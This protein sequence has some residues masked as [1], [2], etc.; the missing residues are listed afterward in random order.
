MS[1]IV[2]STPDREV[3]LRTLADLVDEA[4]GVGMNIEVSRTGSETGPISQ[5]RLIPVDVVGGNAAKRV[6]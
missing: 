3:F 4:G 2:T 6:E 5:I 1:G